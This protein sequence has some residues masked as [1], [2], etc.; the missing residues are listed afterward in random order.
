MFCSKS[1]IIH[2]GLFKVG[3][4]GTLRLKHVNVSVETIGSGKLCTYNKSSSVFDCVY[5]VVC[6]AGTIQLGSGIA[7]GTTAC[8]SCR[9]SS[10]YR[11]T[12]ICNDSTYSIICI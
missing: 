1:K 10:W 11:N 5:D 6:P 7:T 12:A 3:N 2:D 9:G 8:S 4:G